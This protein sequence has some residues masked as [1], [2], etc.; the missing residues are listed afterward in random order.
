MH[1][2]AD[3]KG[4][5]TRILAMIRPDVFFCVTSRNIDD[6]A[7]DFSFKKNRLNLE[8]YWDLVIAPIQES[9]WWNTPVPKDNLERRIWENRTAL[10]DIFYFNQSK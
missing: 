9:V 7:M 3:P 10:L 4:I 6:L 1:Q 2:E 8:T 5:V